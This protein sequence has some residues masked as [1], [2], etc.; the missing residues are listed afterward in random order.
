MTLEERIEQQF[1]DMDI[2]IIEN[3]IA[4][5]DLDIRILELEARN[6]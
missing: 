5:T 2:S 4:R 3:E 1:T 6:E